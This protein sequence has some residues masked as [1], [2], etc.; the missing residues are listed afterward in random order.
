MI[1]LE[2]RSQITP[3]LHCFSIFLQVNWSTSIGDVSK[4]KMMSIAGSLERFSTHPIASCILAEAVNNGA[5]VDLP[6]TQTTA[7]AGMF[8]LF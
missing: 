7:E 8:Q 4:E 1:V 5:I 6:V 2:Q 3:L